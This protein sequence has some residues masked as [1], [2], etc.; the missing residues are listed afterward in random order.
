M[1]ARIEGLGT[2][3]LTIDGVAELGA[4]AHRVVTDRVVSGTYLA[5]GLITKGP[6]G[7]STREPSTW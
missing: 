2:S 5:S 1:G 3:L 4:A 7:S 6:C